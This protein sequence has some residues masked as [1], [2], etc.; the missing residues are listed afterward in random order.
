MSPK[1]Y[2]EQWVL[3]AFSV[4]MDTLQLFL[5]LTHYLSVSEF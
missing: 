1:V 2:I 4:T 5:N 3:T